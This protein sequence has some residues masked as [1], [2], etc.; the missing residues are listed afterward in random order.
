[1]EDLRSHRLRWSHDDEVV[2]RRASRMD[3]LLS[4]TLVL[5]E[6]RRRH[7]HMLMGRPSL[8]VRHEVRILAE[9]S[10]GKKGV[11]HGRG[12]LHVDTWVVQ[13][14]RVGCAQTWRRVPRLDP[15]EETW[16][17]GRSRSERSLLVRLGVLDHSLDRLEVL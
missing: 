1:M 9:G 13:R 12:N 17:M 4:E 15:R 14:F 6:L 7:V 11:H 10:H 16:L 5:G 8:H 2:G 3:G